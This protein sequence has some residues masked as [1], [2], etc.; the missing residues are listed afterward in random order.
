V[1]ENGYGG[2]SGLFEVVFPG[3]F[4]CSPVI[5]TDIPA[6]CNPDSN[7]IS[8]PLFGTLPNNIYWYDSSGVLLR[9]DTNLLTAD[10]ISLLPHGYYYALISDNGTCGTDSLPFFI[11]EPVSMK[12]D[13][14]HAT[15]CIGCNDGEI[16]FHPQG[17]AAPYSYIIN[18]SVVIVTGSPVAPLAPGVYTICVT[19]IN[20]CVSCDSI[21][22][23][24]DPTAVIDP[25][26][27]GGFV[28]YPNP[29]SNI[30][31]LRF[32]GNAVVSVRLLDV[33]GNEYLSVMNSNTS[34]AG[35]EMKINCSVLP[36]GCYTIEVKTAGKVSY[37][38]LVVMN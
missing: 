28:V 31:T 9:T 35:N 1:V 36:D 17:G 2:T 15:D 38:R 14:V 11:P 24:E 19:D 30:A 18:P 5:A 16:Y 22:V 10:T 27:N 33:T 20:G 8:I 3:K 21:E 7:F 37:S 6:I 26:R 34:A 12:I 32:A 23:L 13:S 4:P 25:Q 29:A